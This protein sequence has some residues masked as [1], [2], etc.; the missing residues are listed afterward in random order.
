[1]ADA[2]GAFRFD[3]GYS[4]PASP[5]SPRMR[6]A[7][8]S[9]PPPRYLEGQAEHVVHSSPGDSRFAIG[10]RVFHVKFGYGRIEDIEGN[11]LEIAFEKAGTKKVID[12]F[13]E[14][15]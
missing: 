2:P 11:K 1:M 7:G 4:A 10:E 14:P 15:A 8:P 6:R 3:D 5:S 12:S 13:V 9:A